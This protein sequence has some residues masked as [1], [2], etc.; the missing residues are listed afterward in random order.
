MNKTITRVEEIRSMTDEQLAYFLCRMS[1]CKLC[2][3]SEYCYEGHNGFSD[4]LKE[5]V[6]VRR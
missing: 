4:W 5:E 3:A 2:S 6:E 1:S